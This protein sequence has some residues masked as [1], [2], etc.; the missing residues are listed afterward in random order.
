MMTPMAEIGGPPAPWIGLVKAV[1][2][3]SAWLVVGVL[4]AAAG[5]ASSMDS[6]SGAIDVL[7]ALDV[8]LSLLGAGFVVAAGVA[9]MRRRR[10]LYARL[11]AGA[12]FGVWV[13]LA[14]AVVG[15][16]FAA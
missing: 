13:F 4:L 15:V 6:S 10:T 14:L 3:A 2:L 1:L 16:V 5:A 12:C 8:L 9:G 7:L 11:G